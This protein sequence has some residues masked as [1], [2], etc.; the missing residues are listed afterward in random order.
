MHS[1]PYR[2]KEAEGKVQKSSSTQLL[3]RPDLGPGPR[4]ECLQS[5]QLLPLLCGLPGA[6]ARARRKFPRKRMSTSLTAARSHLLSISF[7]KRE[8]VREGLL[9]AFVHPL[10]KVRPVPTQPA[11][12]TQGAGGLKVPSYCSLP[13]SPAH[14]H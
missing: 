13:P 6:T 1:R 5:S 3:P 7:Q 2:R 8:L 12:N 4:Q 14:I 9:C 10:R 11:A